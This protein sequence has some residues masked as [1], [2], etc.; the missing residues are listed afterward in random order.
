MPWQVLISIAVVLLS[1]AIIQQRMILRR[2]SVDETAFATVFQLSVAFVLLP[3][4]LFHGISFRG[5]DDMALLI[6]LS[7]ACFGLGSVVYAKSL[8]RVDASAFSVLFATQ[9]IW[10]M[11]T[12][13][14]FLHETLTRWQMLGSILILGSVAILVK[15]IHRI[16]IEKGFG[17]GLLTGLLFGVALAASAYISRHTEPITWV[18]ASFVLGSLGSLLAN[19]RKIKACVKLV[20]RSI[21]RKLLATSVLYGLGT[22][23]MT[24]AY[25]DGPLSLVAPV[26]QSGI[27]VTT[28][29]AFILIRQERRDI[30]RKI[31]AAFVC[32]LGVVLT[33]L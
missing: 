29:L 6:V 7:G 9:T 3:I 31:T 5:F 8:E 27:V 26:R 25:I 16:L 32:F 24:Y 19:P 30:T 23:A 2:H 13:S 28:L 10:I 11:L 21:M 15:N 1:L 17:L 33:V 22:I 4:A 14:I 12:G 20:H 18:I